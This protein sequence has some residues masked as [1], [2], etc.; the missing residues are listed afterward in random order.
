MMAV[1]VAA[2]LPIFILIRIYWAGPFPFKPYRD[3]LPYPRLGTRVR[4]L[5]HGSEKES[6]REGDGQ[7]TVAKHENGS[8]G[9]TS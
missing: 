7:S 3:V 8:G 5:G 9:R 4:N 2:A 1:Q 6:K